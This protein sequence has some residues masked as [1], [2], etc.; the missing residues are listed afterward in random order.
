[1]DTIALL[2]ALGNNGN[3]IGA[4]VYRL[5]DYLIYKLPPNDIPNKLVKHNPGG[6]NPIVLFMPYLFQDSRVLL[7]E[8]FQY[9][10][11]LHLHLHCAPCR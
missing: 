11:E 10:R 9:V 7:L 6:P 3:I 8:G 4:S 2:D 5:I 1:M